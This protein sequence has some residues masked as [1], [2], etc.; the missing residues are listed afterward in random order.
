MCNVN[1]VVD[2]GK[3]IVLF[4]CNGVGK[5]MLLC[6]L[7]G[8]VVVKSGSVLWCGIVFGVLL[9]YVCVVVGFVYVL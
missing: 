9:L 6:C 2:D 8:V 5:S 4:G 1:F 7:M 3:F